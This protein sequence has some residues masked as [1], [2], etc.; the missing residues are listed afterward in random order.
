L[1]DRA[2]FGAENP[3]LVDEEVMSRWE[4]FRK[5]G[6]VTRQGVYAV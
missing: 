5:R 4:V 3:Q 2:F 6:T 1:Y